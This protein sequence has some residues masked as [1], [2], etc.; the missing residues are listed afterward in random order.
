[1]NTALSPDGTALPILTT[2][3]NTGFYTQAAD[4]TAIV[5]PALDPTTGK[6]T[7]TTTPNAEWV[8]VYDVRGQKPVQKQRINIPNMFNRS[9]N[10]QMEGIIYE[11]GVPIR[12]CTKG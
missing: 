4:G 10:C 2:G 5:W 9:G 3:Y 8:F 6:P 1:M 11:N 7:S 12:F